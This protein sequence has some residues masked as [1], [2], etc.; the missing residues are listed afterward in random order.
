MMNREWARWIA[1]S[2]NNHFKDNLVLSSIPNL[3]VFFEANHRAT[4]SDQFIIE[5]RQDGGYWLENIKD[6]W[7]GTYEINL[8]IQ[9]YM[10][11]KD[12]YRVWDLIGLANEAMSKPISIFKFGGS[13]NE[14]FLGCLK[15]I[16]DKQDIITHFFGQIDP[17][18]NVVQATV[19]AHYNIE[20]ES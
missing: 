6:H 4:E 18:I 19:E 1:A 8:L 10:D 14:E 9:Y 11:D 5:V 12:N 16:D 7:I 20:L 2:I 15:L 3:K 17:K 13:G